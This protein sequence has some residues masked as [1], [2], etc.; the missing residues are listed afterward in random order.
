VCPPASLSPSHPPS[1]PLPATLGLPSAPFD[2][3]CAPTPTP[4]GCPFQCCRW[5][6][7]A[8][9]PCVREAVGMLSSLDGDEDVVCQP[10]LVASAN[11]TLHARVLEYSVPRSGLTCSPFLHPWSYTR[12]RTSGV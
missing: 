9:A 4:A 2:P 3:R 10:N 1:L 12:S 8:V 11:P 5:D 7:A 6:I